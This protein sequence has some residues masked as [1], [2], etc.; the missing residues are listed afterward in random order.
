M[1]LHYLCYYIWSVLETQEAE[2]ENLDEEL[3]VNNPDE[4]LAAPISY[5]HNF[6]RN[7]QTKPQR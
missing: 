2:P 6:Y 1:L 4:E 3:M 5:A 7:P